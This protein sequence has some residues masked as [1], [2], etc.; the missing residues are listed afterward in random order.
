[1]SIFR[2]DDAGP[3]PTLPVPTVVMP[4][5][6]FAISVVYRELSCFD[7]SKAASPD[8]IHLQMVRWL[9]D[10]VAGPLSKLFSNSLTTAVVLTGAW[11]SYA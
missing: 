9:A 2:E 6:H 8:D 7:S 4:V 1:M 11:S 3:T 5:P 10:V